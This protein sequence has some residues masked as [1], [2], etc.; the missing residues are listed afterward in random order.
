MAEASQ[1]PTRE[2]SPKID[3]RACVASFVTASTL[4]TAHIVS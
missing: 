1:L 3:K 4:A 2:I